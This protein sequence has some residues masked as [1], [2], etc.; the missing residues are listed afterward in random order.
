MLDATCELI[1]IHMPRRLDRSAA[2]HLAQDFDTQILAG[3]GIVLDFSQ[4]LMLDPE[5]TSVVEESLI[6]AR[7]HGVQMSLRAVPA[8]IKQSLAAAGLLQYFH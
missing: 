4:T 3:D 7:Q 8:P 5:A 2:A 6:I 1:I